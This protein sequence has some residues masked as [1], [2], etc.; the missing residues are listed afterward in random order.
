[1][2]MKAINVKVIVEEQTLVEKTTEGGIFLPENREEPQKYG[3]VIS[4]GPDVKS[5]AVGNIIVFHRSLGMAMMMEGKVY[6]VL[7]EPEV[8][9]I[10]EEEPAANA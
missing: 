7:N 6:R 2:K 10:L 1:M 9:C 5:I 4:V 8:Y 3:R